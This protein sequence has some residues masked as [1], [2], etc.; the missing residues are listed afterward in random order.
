MFLTLPLC[1]QSW[2]RLG[3]G[4]SCSSLPLIS[5]I[6]AMD[7]FPQLPSVALSVF[8]EDPLRRCIYFAKHIYSLSLID[9]L[10]SKV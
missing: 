3:N 4:Q 9:H 2:L 5:I 7:P 8:P 6:S 1:C 10:S